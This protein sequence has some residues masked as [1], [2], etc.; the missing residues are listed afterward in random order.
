MER[1]V[2]EIENIDKQ[3]YDMDQTEDHYKQKMQALQEGIIQL[4]QATGTE[5]DDYLSLIGSNGITE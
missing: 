4:F 3:M 5:T 2:N 1:I